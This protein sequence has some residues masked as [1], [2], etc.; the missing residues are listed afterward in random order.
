[1]ICRL[2]RLADCDRRSGFSPGLED[3]NSIALCFVFDKR[4][5]ARYNQKQENRS[6]SEAT[7]DENMTSCCFTGH[8]PEKLPWGAD[9]RDPRCV[10]LKEELACHLE[11][12]YLAGIRRFIC[13][14]A[15]GGASPLRSSAGRERRGDLCRTLL[16]ARL[17]AAAQSVHGRLLRCAARCVQ[18]HRRRDDEHDPLCAAKRLAGHHDRDIGRLPRAPGRPC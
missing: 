15:R 4:R 2:L 10:K 9:E 12:L 1:M 13:G 17:Y 18:R 7:M 8:R 11:G 16:C 5:S 6:E 14:M 3:G